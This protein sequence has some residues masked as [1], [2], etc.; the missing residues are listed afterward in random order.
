MQWWR[1][2]TAG[3]RSELATQ[4]RLDDYEQLQQAMETQSKMMLPDQKTKATS[5]KGSEQTGG[6]KEELTLKRASEKQN[7]DEPS[8]KRGSRLTRGLASAYAGATWIVVMSSLLLVTMTRVCQ[9]HP[10][11]APS[12]LRLLLRV[13]AGAVWGAMLGVAGMKRAHPTRS[14]Q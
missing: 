4:Q 11:D 8:M 14:V 12:R 10:L 13:R 9:R 5:S 2:H 3:Q 1:K 6:V 7:S